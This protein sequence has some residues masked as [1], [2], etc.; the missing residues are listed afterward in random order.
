LIVRPPSSSCSRSKVPG[1]NSGEWQSEPIPDGG[2][3]SCGDIQRDLGR[4]SGKIQAFGSCGPPG[5]IFQLS[6]R[7][8]GGSPHLFLFVSSPKRSAIIIA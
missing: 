4:R 7:A 3:P 2:L 1:K 5:K 8:R 6:Y